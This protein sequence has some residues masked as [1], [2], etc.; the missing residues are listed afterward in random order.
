MKTTTLA[1]AV[2]AVAALVE[3][4]P[5]NER[6]DVYVNYPYTGPSTPIA[7]WVDQSI[8]G[9]GKGFIRLV[10]A[11]AVKPA[12][13]KPT[14]NINVISLAYVPGGMNVHFST[15]FSLGVAPSLTY[16]VDS[17]NLQKFATGV[18]ST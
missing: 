3:A 8:N 10:E 16:G 2:A 11:P 12:K 17:G 14:N 1:G 6:R 5:S 13:I 7:D 9:N 4:L 18:T 15:P